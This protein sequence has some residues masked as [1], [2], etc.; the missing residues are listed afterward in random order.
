L[1]SADLTKTA[2]LGHILD[3][4]FDAAALDSMVD[5]LHGDNGGLC[6]MEHRMVKWRFRNGPEIH[7]RQ[8]LEGA[9]AVPDRNDRLIEFLAR[10]W[11]TCGRGDMG[12]LEELAEAGLLD[13]E[14]GRIR[15]GER[16]MHAIFMEHCRR[17]HVADV[18]R[19]ID[20]EIDM[21]VNEVDALGL[22][23]FMAALFGGHLEI[24]QMLI[25]RRPE[26]NLNAE[27]GSERFTAQVWAQRLAFLDWVQ[28]IENG[29]RGQSKS[30]DQFT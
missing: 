19:M 17:G 20:P 27:F 30:S 13:W 24:G 22:S 10:A 26:L 1:I 25:D 6:T 29:M 9:V 2:L 16:L 14:G 5:W 23:A 4:P 15:W 28:I 12:W 21:D 11:L 18:G 7:L 3:E 8:E